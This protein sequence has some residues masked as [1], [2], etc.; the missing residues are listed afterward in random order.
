MARK[1]KFMA[2]EEKCIREETE[3]HCYLKRLV[4]ADF[5]KLV[6][7]IWCCLT[8]A[9]LMHLTVCMIACCI[10]TVV[11]CVVLICLWLVNL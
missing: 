2:A 11:S 10:S 9:S 8:V 4:N 7:L 1:K 6:H 3:L 5:E